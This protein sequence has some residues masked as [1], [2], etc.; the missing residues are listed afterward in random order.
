MS[1]V[2]AN[3]ED[4]ERFVQQLKNFTEQMRSG[5]SN[6]NGQFSRLGET[7]RDQEHS[8]YAQEFEQTMR[9]LQQFIR[10]SEQQAPFLMRKAQRLREFLNQR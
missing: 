9:V 10:S 2:I 3:P 5:V 4:I 1:G 6:M 7:W 8:K